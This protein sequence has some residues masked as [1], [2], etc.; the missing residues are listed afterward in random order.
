MGERIFVDTV[1]I[2]ALI[3]KRD[4]YH[5][6]AIRLADEIQD[7]NLVTT[8][9]VMDVTPQLF[10]KACIYIKPDRIRIGAW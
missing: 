9:A 7:Q 5:S 2:L 10:R 1:Y 3:N 6:E 4:Q 8:T